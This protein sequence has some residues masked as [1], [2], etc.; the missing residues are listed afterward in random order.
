LQAAVLSTSNPTYAEAF[1]VADATGKPLVDKVA[2]TVLNT[3]HHG[4][5][6]RE[7][8]GGGSI[9]QLVMYHRAEGQWRRRVL[10]G[11]HSPSEIEAFIN[12]GVSETKIES[13]AQ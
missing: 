1:E 5:L 3:D 12:Q 9:P 10:V 4:Q 13:A 6:A 11:N 7:I 8:T 2:Y